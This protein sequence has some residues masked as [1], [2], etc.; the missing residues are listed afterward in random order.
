MIPKELLSKEYIARLTVYADKSY[1]RATQDFVLFFAREFKFDE[2][3]LKKLEL[4]TEEAVLSTIENSFESDELESFD[5]KVSYRPGAFVIS[6]EDKGL[7]SDMEHLQKNENTALEILLMRNLADEF[8]IINLGREGKRLELVKYLT[9]TS[10]AD[11]PS[12]NEKK[13]IP[14]DE[15]EAATD[16]P[17]MRLV[18]PE[19]AVNLSRLAYRV[20]GYTYSSVF[21]YPDK[22]RELIEDGLLMSV[23][24]INKDHQI[25][26]NLS[27][28]FEHKEAP[29]AD[30]GAAM[31]DPR[32]RGHSLFKESKKYL[33]AYAKNHDMFGIYSE[34]VT[35]HSYTQQGN[36]SLGARETGIMLAY[37]SQ[38]LTFKKI[39]GER[40][41][42]RQAVVLFYLKIS[43]EPHRRV[44]L[45][46][47]FFTLLSNIY[48]R[49]E[50]D[51]EV[52]MVPDTE[53]PEIPQ[54]L[55]L[56]S[57]TVKPD[58]NIAVISVQKQ[59]TDAIDLIKHQLRELCLKK[60]ETIYLEIPIDKPCSALLARE[61][62]MA[63]FMLSGI[64]PELRNGDVLK[65]QYLN[66]VTVDP[67]KIVLASSI[68]KELLDIIMSDYR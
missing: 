35:I 36:I 2:I 28:F 55:S 54:Y 16:I 63:G 26:G 10:I 53:L 21:Y 50:L 33:M 62:N 67:E 27:L 40:T 48:Q 5:V 25:V 18:Q 49:L 24:S 43:Q 34:S 1:I 20:Y 17:T 52:I 30:S 61:M 7:P 22:I 8:N 44:Y 9:E 64:I 42:Q 66:N 59:G 4:I 3:E 46:E 31:I 45:N 23:V 14:E 13:L 37:A 58:L 12:R 47:K 6:I 38:S 29:V 68:A 41:G 56:V 32:Y 15:Q 19:D 39:G 57:T 11:M 65:M 60:I 51:R